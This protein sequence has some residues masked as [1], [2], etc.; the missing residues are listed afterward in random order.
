MWNIYTIDTLYVLYIY[1]TALTVV[2]WK[3]SSFA[4]PQQPAQPHASHPPFLQ[5]LWAVCCRWG[6][7]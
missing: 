5:M 7:R 3:Q 4:V 6:P 2:A 1:S